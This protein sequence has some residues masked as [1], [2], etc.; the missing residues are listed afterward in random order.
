MLPTV[1]LQYQ[2]QLGQSIFIRFKS[3]Y[4]WFIMLKGDKV[5][6]KIYSRRIVISVR[7]KSDQ[8]IIHGIIET[9]AVVI[10]NIQRKDIF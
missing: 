7:N 8:S 4:C 6:E 3:T 9:F 5:G 10:F 2:C 1:S